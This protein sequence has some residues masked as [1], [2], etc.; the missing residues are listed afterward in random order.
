[1][2]G[3][4]P[5]RSL[6]PAA[7]ARIR[8]IAESVRFKARTVAADERETGE[9]ALLN[10]GHTFA[11]ALEAACGYDADGS[12]MARRSRSAWCWRTIFPSP[13]ALRRRRTRSACAR[14]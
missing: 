8:A 4:K 12:S 2:A 3:G 7:P 14:I 13:R 10:L 1:M 6:S 5:R 9:R 11:H